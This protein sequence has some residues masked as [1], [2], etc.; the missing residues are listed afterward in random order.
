MFDLQAGQAL[1]QT[2]KRQAKELVARR[3]DLAGRPLPR[4]ARVDAEVRV[5]SGDE[6][7]ALIRRQPGTPVGRLITAAARI[8]VVAPVLDG[9]ID[10]FI[11][12][13]LAQRMKGGGPAVVEDLE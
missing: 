9:E 1:A 3:R 13:A 2:R 12:S 6:L 8:G 4:H 5:S 7:G 10:P 11:E